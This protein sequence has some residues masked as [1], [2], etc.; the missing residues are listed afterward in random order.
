MHMDVIETAL[1]EEHFVT[2]HDIF[3]EKEEEDVNKTYKCDI[4][5]D[6]KSH[7]KFKLVNHKRKCGPKPKIEIVQEDLK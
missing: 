3:H 1:L 6:Y 2:N 7:S 4:C 5:K